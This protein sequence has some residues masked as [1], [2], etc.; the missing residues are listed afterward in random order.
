MDSRQF[1]EW[2]LLGDTAPVGCLVRQPP[3]LTPV[4]DLQVWAPDGLGEIRA[5]D[6]LP[7]LLVELLRVGRPLC[8]GDVLVLTSKVVSK[9]EGRQV[10]ADD[11]EAAITAQTVRVVAT[12]A[13]ARGVTRIV[14]NPLGLVMAAAGVD[15]SNTPAGQVLLLPVDPDASARAVRAAVQAAFG[16]QVGVLVSDTAGRAW[17]EG[18]VDLAIG[19]AGVRVLD[20][21][22]GGVDTAGKQLEATVVAIADELAAAADLVKGKTAGRPLAVVRGAGRYVGA[23]DGPGARAA[24]RPASEDLFRLGTAEA[25]AAGLADGRRGCAEPD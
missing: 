19:A 17:R 6:D 5:G 24:I 20:D 23:E 9:A 21:L 12:R 2:V 11:R 15:A 16:V 8:D 4:D 7:A 1:L 13:H 10:R 18:V 14:E 25:Y 3:R 22:R